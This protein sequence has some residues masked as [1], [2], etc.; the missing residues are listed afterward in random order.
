MD[1]NVYFN[2][3]ILNKRILI[4][5]CSLCIPFV[6]HAQKPG[7][8]IEQDPEILELEKERI[9]LELEAERVSMQI[10]QNRINKELQLARYFG[11]KYFNPAVGLTEGQAT[12][13][14]VPIGYVLGPEVLNHPTRSP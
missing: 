4:I 8:I 6:M 2:M 13:L 10:E 7:E 5:I 3:F 12:N 11:Y 9:H 1:K 14:P